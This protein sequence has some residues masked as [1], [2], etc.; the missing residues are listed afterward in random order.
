MDGVL[1]DYSSFFHFWADDFLLYWFP[2][3]CH[4]RI[5]YIRFR[6]SNFLFLV[7]SDS[8][9]SDSVM[10][11]SFFG[12]YQIPLHQ[13]PLYQI[14]FF[15]YISFRY[16]RVRYINFPFLLHQIPLYQFPEKM[17]HQIPLYQ[18]LLY[19]LPHPRP[20]CNLVLEEV[21]SKH[22]SN[23]SADAKGPSQIRKY[24]LH[25]KH[26]NTADNELKSSPYYTFE[27]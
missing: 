25:Q 21:H 11:V 22:H 9:T 27:C 3:Y 4:I 5:R 20:R 18:I 2:S 19:Q 14:P 6:Y 17:L 8:V 26:N 10:S 24:P 15:G 23:A 13:I 12:L 16:I 7:I 1:A